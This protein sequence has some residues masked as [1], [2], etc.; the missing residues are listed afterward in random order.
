[1]TAQEIKEKFDA[2]IPAPKCEL[3]YKSPYQLLIAVILSAQ[4]TDKRVN[5]VTKEMFKKYDTPEKVTSLA[6]EELEEIIH[7]CG[8]YKK[9]KK[10]ILVMTKDVIEKYNGQAL[11][12]N[13]FLLQVLEEKRQTS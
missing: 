2:L 5:M 11:W 8:F 7:S 10:N 3:D 13:L 4:C 12:K 6:Q 1:M 9:K